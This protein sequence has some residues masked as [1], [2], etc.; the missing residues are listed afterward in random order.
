[1]PPEGVT[2]VG[3]DPRRPSSSCLPRPLLRPPGGRQDLPRAGQ[4]RGSGGQQGRAPPPLGS[5]FSGPGQ[6]GAGLGARALRTVNS[7]HGA[8]SGRPTA[9]ALLPGKSGG[10]VSQLHGP[11]ALQGVS[12]GPPGGRGVSGVGG[13]AGT[14]AR[15]AVVPV[16]AQVHL[17]G[18]GTVGARLVL[19]AVIWGAPWG[20]AAGHR[21]VCPRASPAGR[22]LGQCRCPGSTSRRASARPSRRSWCTQTMGWCTT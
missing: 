11:G 14:A 16:A 2:Y 3:A 17:D 8:L 15:L 10:S 7:P 18:Q 1:M 21:P 13:P 20:R 22:S 6:P 9:Q 4:A 5:T 12:V 19:A